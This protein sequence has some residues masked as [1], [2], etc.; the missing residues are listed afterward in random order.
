MLKV[1]WRGMVVVVVVGVEK[2]R[3][4]ARESERAPSTMALE[5]RLDIME[6]IIGTTLSWRRARSTRSLAMRRIYG[7]INREG[8]TKNMKFHSLRKIKRKYFGFTASSLSLR[9]V[10]ASMTSLM[11]MTLIASTFT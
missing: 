11:S 7:V 8:E 9:F 2:I 1:V 6:I 4:R 3:S 5:I 10:T